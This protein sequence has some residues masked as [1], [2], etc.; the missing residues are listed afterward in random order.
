MF[1][2]DKLVGWLTE[3][4][5]RGYNAIVNEV[6]NTVTAISCSEEGKATLEIIQFDSKIK[7]NINKGKP[8]VDV[9][10]KVKGNVGEVECQINLNDPQ[11]IV[12]PEKCLKE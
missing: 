8:V 4:E 1:K 7:G 12:V 2:K 6:Q 5:A 3:R 9:N 10:I 11:T